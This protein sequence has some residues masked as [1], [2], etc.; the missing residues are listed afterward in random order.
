MVHFPKYVEDA[1]VSQESYFCLM[2]PFAKTGSRDIHVRLAIYLMELS[3]P[4]KHVRRYL[5]SPCISH[6]DAI[7]Y[8]GHTGTEV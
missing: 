3:H 7:S 2:F 4:K 1:M 6:L 5:K 8:L